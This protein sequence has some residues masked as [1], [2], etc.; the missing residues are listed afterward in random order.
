MCWSVE[1]LMP[2][3]SPDVPG[4]AAPFQPWSQPLEK[5]LVSV[6]PLLVLP[7]G[8]YCMTWPTFPP[9]LSWAAA[10]GW[11]SA[12][13]CQAAD[14]CFLPLHP[15]PTIPL[16]W[17]KLPWACRGKKPHQDMAVLCLSASFTRLETRPYN[18]VAS[19]TCYQVQSVAMV[20]ICRCALGVLLQEW[21]IVCGLFSVVIPQFFLSPRR[22]ITAC[23]CAMLQ[24]GLWSAA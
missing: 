2:R 20:H 8:S 6:S 23:G 16:C 17:E 13:L 7:S 15:C 21:A 9:Y 22:R 19:H 1:G 12:G 24:A 10:W 4:E 11:V 18:Q 3:S 5:S 14:V